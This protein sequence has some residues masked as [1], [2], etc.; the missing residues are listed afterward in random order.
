MFIYRFSKLIKSKLIWCFL[1]FLMAFAFVF[2]D[3]CSSANTHVETVTMDGEDITAHVREDADLYLRLVDSNIGINAMFNPNFLRANMGMGYFFDWALLNAANSEDG[4]TDEMRELA[5]RRYWSVVAATVAAERMGLTA[6]TNKGSLGYLEKIYSDPANPED[7]NSERVFNAEAYAAD[8]QKLTFDASKHDVRFKRMFNNVIYPLTLAT[9]AIEY[10]TGWVSPME[11]DFYLSTAYDTTVARAIVLK[12]TRDAKTIPVSE[13]AIAQWYDT[14]KQRYTHPEKRAIEYVTVPV[15]SFVD[16]ATAKCNQEEG[17][18]EV[19]ALEYYE[20]NRDEFKD[21]KGEQ[22]QYEGDV[23]QKAIEKVK[24]REAIALAIET[25]NETVSTLGNLPVDEATTRFAEE[26]IAPYGA[27]VAAEVAKTGA[28]TVDAAIRTKTFEMGYDD[29][30]E[31]ILTPFEL[32]EGD[33]CVYVIRLKGVTAEKQKTLEEIRTI[34]TEACQ[35]AIIADELKVTNENILKLIKDNMAAGKTLQEACDAVKTISNVTLTDAVE[36]VLSGEE[37]KGDYATE[38]KNGAATLGP[39][40]FSASTYK[41][42]EAITVYVEKRYAKANDI[43]KS[44]NRYGLAVELSRQ[45]NYVKQW[46][47]SNLMATPP[48]NGMDQNLLAPQAE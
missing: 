41:P 15:T 33:D 6:A 24:T 7:P 31:T 19:L 30:A 27:A 20:N 44:T 11:L 16:A 8:L 1:I 17:G 25:L 23:V 48:M 34:A 43:A 12:D 14:N 9:H 40:Q 36:F 26:I 32:C 45:N 29:V 28:T 18:I 47:E 21:D 5:L 35:K 2:A 3:A 38:I 42:T 46:L 4:I 13:E 39:Q 37:P 10:T 22:L